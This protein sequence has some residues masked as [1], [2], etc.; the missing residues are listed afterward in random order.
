MTKIYYATNISTTGESVD[1]IRIANNLRQLGYEVYA[2][3]ENKA[4]NDK[5]NDP[6]PKDIYD[7]DVSEIITSDVFVVNLTGSHQDGTISE[8]GLVAGF[9]EANSFDSEEKR[10]LRDTGLSNEEI[11]YIEG[12]IPIVAF[13]TNTRIMQP[14]HYWNIPSASANHLVLG[15]IEKYGTFVGDERNLYEYLRTELSHVKK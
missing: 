3:A 1:S 14:Q 8:I 9:N 15:M 4:I 11:D 6:T 5:S 2:A 10:K 12:N 7:G 13:T